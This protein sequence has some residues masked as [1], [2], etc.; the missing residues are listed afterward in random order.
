MDINFSPIQTNGRMLWSFS[1]TAYE[2]AEATIPNMEKYNINPADIDNNFGN[3][4][5]NATYRWRDLWW[6]GFCSMERIEYPYLQDRDFLVKL[7]NQL[8][9]RI[10]TK[11]TLLQWDEKPIQEIQGYITGGSLTI[12]GDSAIRR[13]GN[14]SVYLE[15]EKN[16]KITEVSNLYS[17]SLK[18][19][20]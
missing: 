14:L 18:G 17:N 20:L 11:I 4:N 3:N 1:A 8:S 2:M 12:N 9:K 7:D 10:H 13:A 5:K 15:D 6:R 16:A 19:F